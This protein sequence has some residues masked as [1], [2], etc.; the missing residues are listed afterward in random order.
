MPDV[1]KVC[2]PRPKGSV[3]WNGKEIKG[4]SFAVE[5]WDQGLL[6]VEV[7]VCP[8]KLLFLCLSFS[9]RWKEKWL[10]VKGTG[11]EQNWRQ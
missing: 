7:T 6:P 4:S 9:C 3:A 5:A 1:L 2:F 10:S 11:G 8:W